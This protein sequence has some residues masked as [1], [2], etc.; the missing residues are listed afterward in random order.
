MEFVVFLCCHN[1]NCKISGPD[2]PYFIFIPFNNNPRNTLQ[3]ENITQ[4]VSP[5]KAFNKTSLQATFSFP[6]KVANN[7]IFCIACCGLRYFSCFHFK[8][9][10]RDHKMSTKYLL[11]DTFC[12]VVQIHVQTN[13]DTSVGFYS[14]TFENQIAVAVANSNF[15]GEV[16]DKENVS[17]AREVR[18]GY[19]LSVRY[20]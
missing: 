8:V 3:Q 4:F 20:L 19:T 10:K 5:L 13:G 14:G 18:L 16:G 6:Q 17:F 2:M 15:N 9:G 12:I 11:Q 1:Y 7:S